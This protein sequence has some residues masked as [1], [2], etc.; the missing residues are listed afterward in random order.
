LT[1]R[2]YT[3]DEV[4]LTHQSW[5]AMIRRCGGKSKNPNDRPYAT[6]K[7]HPA[8]MDFHVFMEDVGPRLTKEHTLDRYPLKRGDYVPGNVR[9]AGKKAQAVNRT[10]TR[11]IEFNGETLPISYWAKR[12]GTQGSTILNRLT[13]GWDLARAL[14][15]PPSPSGFAKGR[16]MGKK[17]TA[18][19][20]ESLL[21]KAQSG[22]YTLSELA[23]EFDVGVPSVLNILCRFGVKAMKRYSKVLGAA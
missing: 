7:I 12:L 6:V 14:T 16:L 13:K 3:I 20:V 11:L 15:E 2:K 10:S 21:H 1:D 22:K 5:I 23:R 9:W 8:W 19:Q 17:L 18:Q 4:L